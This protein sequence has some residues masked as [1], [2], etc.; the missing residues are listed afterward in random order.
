MIQISLQLAL[1]LKQ[2]KKDFLLYDIDNDNKV[3]DY[4]LT[5]DLTRYRKQF[6]KFRLIESITFNETVTI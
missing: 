3:V 1:K 2:T 6:D 5:N 4:K